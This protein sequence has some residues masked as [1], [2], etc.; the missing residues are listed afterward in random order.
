MKLNLTLVLALTSSIGVFAQNAP[1]TSPVASAPTKTSEPL[2]QA[3]ID[4]IAAMTPIFDGKTLNGW[5]QSPIN[6][7]LA[8]AD[9][10]NIDAFAKKISDKS[11]TV[12]A[13][14]NEQLD[15][16]GKSS[17]AGLT[18]TDANAKAAISALVKSLNKVLN[19]ASI[20]EEKRFAGV[21]LSSGTQELLKKAPTGADLAHL[22][23]LLLEDAYPSDMAKSKTTSWEVKDGAMASTG[24]GRGVIY[25][26]NDYAHYRI[27]FEM[28]Q[29]S[30]NPGH[31]PCVLFFCTRPAAGE[32]GLDAL[33][34]I[35]FQVPNGGHWDYR[36]GFNKGGDGFKNPTKT[37][38]NNHEWS[39]I[40]ILVNAKDGTARMAVAQ[41]VGTKGIVNLV[42]TNAEAGKTG[43]FALQMHN[44]GLF[45]EYRNV[46]VEIDPKDD[47]LITAE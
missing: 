37:K 17:V 47:K 3:A 9:I 18:S 33:G 14:L 44:G 34:G 35:Q 29:I 22:N 40:E 24:A 28:R 11:D 39:Q 10:S 46:R 13:F 19:G 20:Y 23:R 43:P 8:A 25:S 31:Q 45:D 12:S 4:K 32:K 36:P 1:N 42:Y 38:F 6:Y 30:G 26:Q 7:N 41:P 16:S 2:P 27:V 21:R 5:I 15:E